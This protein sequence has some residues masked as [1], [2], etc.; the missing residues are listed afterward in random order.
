MKI[1][2]LKPAQYAETARVLARAFHN[3]PMWSFLE[4]D[5][6]NRPRT[7]A[8]VIEHWARILAPKG[9]SWIARDIEDRIVGAALWFPPGEFGVTLGRMLRV[10]YVWMPFSLGFGWTTR[11]LRVSREGISHQ[12]ATMKGP[13]WVLDI[14]A[15]DPDAQKSGVGG[16]LIRKGLEIAD[17]QRAP[18]FVVTHNPINVAYYQR[19]GFQLVDEYKV[20]NGGPVA[21]SLRRPVPGESV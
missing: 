16:A 18:S 3:D 19:F 5:A 15:V 8:W 20:S 14:L 21:Y 1:E 11:A 4:P 10:G 6:S 12:I 13:H 9:A 2:V 7:T 17:Q